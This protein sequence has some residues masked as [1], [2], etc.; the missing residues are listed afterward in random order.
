M[1][2]IIVNS[3]G[4]LL[5]NGKKYKCAIGK[6][7]ISNSKQEGDDTTP[8][9]SY[10]IRKIYYRSDRLK[11]P[12]SP[13]VTEELKKSDGWCDDPSDP[14]YNKF[15]SLPYLASHEELWREDNLYDII[16]VLGYNDSPPVPGKGSAIFVHI[17]RPDYLPTAGCIT[18]ARDDLLEILRNCR[19]DTEVVIGN[20][21]GL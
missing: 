3:D 2:S 11:K 12:D 17:A 18:L 21:M 14:K 4:F 15:V 6:N 19:K 1:N 10:K 8:E 7:G 20:K 13:F 16:V 9:G 5:F